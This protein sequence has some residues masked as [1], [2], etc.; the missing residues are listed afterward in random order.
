MALK[1]E[2]SM[3]ISGAHLRKRVSLVDSKSVNGAVY[4]HLSK[5]PIARLAQVLGLPPKVSS[6]NES[7]LSRTNIVEQLTTLRNQNFEAWYA[8]TTPAVAETVDCFEDL[9]T[10]SPAQLPR[11]RKCILATMPD[12]TE[13]A[14]PTIDCVEG[15]SLKMLMGNWH[16]PA[17]LE[18][19]EQATDYLRRVCIHQI[20]S[21]NVKRRRSRRA[22]EAQDEAA[23]PTS[24][25]ESEGTGLS[26]SDATTPTSPCLESQSPDQELTSGSSVMVSPPIKRAGP[27]DK[28]F[29]SKPNA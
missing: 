11:K 13:V 19:T 20:S 25:P 21:G 5:K 14:A 7:T 23:A 22:K 3:T 12:T 15:V 6:G 2:P 10:E 18:L 4:F 8:S 27:L 16:A 28:W 29:K 17:Y 9:L 1:I 26:I 24:E